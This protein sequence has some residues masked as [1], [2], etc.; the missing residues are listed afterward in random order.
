MP[1][2][3]SGSISAFFTAALVHETRAVLAGGD[4]SLGAGIEG[5]WAVK[6]PLFAWALVTFFV[7]PVIVF[8]RP[9]FRGMFTRSAETFRETFGET[10]I[11]LPGVNLLA[12]VA[13]APLLAPGAYLLLVLEAALVGIPRLVAGVL[14]AQ[15]VSY[16]LRDIVKTSLY[17]Y[18]T[19]GD[20]PDEFDGVFDRLETPGDAA[21]PAGP[22]AGGFS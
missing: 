3:S 16:T 2:R 10:P 12:L 6:R 13:A 19:E 9:S 11:G 5:A 8:E 15:L 17:F 1:A 20:R 18:A 14:V 7:I 4:P 22:Q 21:T